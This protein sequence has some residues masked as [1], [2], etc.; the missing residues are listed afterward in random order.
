M[1]TPAGQPLAGAKPLCVKEREDLK[2]LRLS[3]LRKDI[4]AGIAEADRGQFVDGPRAFA[5]IRARSAQRR[6]VRG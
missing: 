2:Q 1:F 5:K 3:E 6:R 4:A